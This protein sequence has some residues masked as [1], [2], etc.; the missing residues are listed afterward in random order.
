MSARET[1][2]HNVAIVARALGEDLEQVVFAG[3]AAA[4]FFDLAPFVTDLPRSGA[5][6]DQLGA[7]APSRRRDEQSHRGVRQQPRGDAA[8]DLVE[9]AARATGV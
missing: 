1:I 7:F 9:P 8:Q 3:A 5:A 4:T 6:N 2:R